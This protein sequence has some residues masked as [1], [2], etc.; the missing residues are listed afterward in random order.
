MRR[1]LLGVLILILP[2]AAAIIVYLVV[3]KPTPTNR[4]ARGGVTTIAGSGSPGVEEGT[5]A[6]ASFSDPFGIAVDRRGNLI[7]AD[8][9]QSNRIRGV[10]VDGKVQTI[11]GSSEGFVDGSAL[12]AQFNTPSGVAID[13]GGDILI[14]DTSNNR[15]RRLS[16]DGSMVSTIAGTGVAG[17]KD[18]PAGRAQFDGPIGVPVDARGKVF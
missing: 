7:V 18:G 12:H 11:A 6:S 5:A 4:D 9:G 17:L 3:T 2:T 8:G 13:R 14:A 1:V 15:I 16:A 10:S